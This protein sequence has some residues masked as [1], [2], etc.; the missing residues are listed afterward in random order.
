MQTSSLFTESLENRRV[1]HFQLS[2]R[3]LK[4]HPSG[5]TLNSSMALSF[6][7]SYFSSNARERPF[8]S[9]LPL[10]FGFFFSRPRPHIPG[11]FW[12]RNFFFSDSKI[13][14]S[15]PH[16]IGFEV[17][18]LYSIQESEFKNNPIRRK[19]A[20]SNIYPDTRGR[21]PTHLRLTLLLAISTNPRGYVDTLHTNFIHYKEHLGVYQP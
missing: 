14:P 9:A 3:F 21:V 8:S 11:Y 13:S 1:Q 19:V 2:L 10:L 12:I 7:T 4:V 16:V 18:L 5:I 6:A 17:D 20:D 15:G